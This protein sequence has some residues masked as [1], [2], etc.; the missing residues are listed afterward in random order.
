MLKNT[1]KK[2]KKGMQVVLV[3]T[4]DGVFI[5]VSFPQS[6]DL[7]LGKVAKKLVLVN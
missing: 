5:L 3:F 4:D 7:T 2:K 1:K 6:L